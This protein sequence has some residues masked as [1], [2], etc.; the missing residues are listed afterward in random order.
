MASEGDAEMQSREPA[1]AAITAASIA[2]PNSIPTAALNQARTARFVCYL[3]QYVGKL[4]NP[5]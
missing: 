3:T 5:Q 4:Y 2:L 1:I